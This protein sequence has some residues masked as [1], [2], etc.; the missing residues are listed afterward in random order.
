MTT[1]RNL[2]KPGSEKQKATALPTNRKN[3]LG[4]TFTLIDSI[5]Q[6]K[7]ETLK[8]GSSLAAATIKLKLPEGL[9][10]ANTEVH[11]LVDT[12]QAVIIK[13]N[14]SLK[15]MNHKITIPN[16]DVTQKDHSD[17]DETLSRVLT[18]K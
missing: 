1:T 6:N 7:L 3:M 11:L 10:Q 2:I 16:S 9:I 17:N 12:K 15:G 13:N 14:I 18:P 8:I 5:S 4:S